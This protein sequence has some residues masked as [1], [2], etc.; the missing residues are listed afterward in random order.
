MSP[1]DRVKELLAHEPDLSDR[2]VCVR[3]GVR[4]Q[5]VLNA[6]S[7]ARLLR[8]RQHVPVPQ[9][10][11]ARLVE[12]GH[13]PKTIARMTGLSLKRVWDRTTVLYRT[14]WPVPRILPVLIE[15]ATHEADDQWA[16]QHLGIDPDL[17][18]NISRCNR[19]LAHPYRTL[20][21]RRTGQDRRYLDPNVEKAQ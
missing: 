2:E 19:M 6:R 12:A 14:H 1:S 16:A 7:R 15:A 20:L 8:Q 13:S 21:A 10:V 11:L 4:S 17:L 9:P 5:T 3:L 18:F